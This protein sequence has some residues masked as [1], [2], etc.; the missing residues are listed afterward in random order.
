MTLTRAT[1]TPRTDF[2][3]GIP[4]FGR[5]HT[6]LFTSQ[7]P[8]I[9]HRQARSDYGHIKADFTFTR[10][11]LPASIG[12]HIISTA[13]SFPTDVPFTAWLNCNWHHRNSNTGDTG[14]VTNSKSCEQVKNFTIFY[15]YPRCTAAFARHRQ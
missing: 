7:E 12:F 13:V 10:H 1:L 14:F 6:L 5:W 9:W 3:Q 15:K 11:V 8:R 4:L 2:R